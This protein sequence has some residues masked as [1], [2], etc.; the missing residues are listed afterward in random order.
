VSVYIVGADGSDLVKIGRASSPRKRLRDMQ[1]GSPLRLKLLGIA[2]APEWADVQLE[3][4]LHAY[5]ATRRRHGEW[6]D[7]NYGGLGSTANVGIGVSR[8]TQRL[9]IPTGGLHGHPCDRLRL[10]L[11]C[12]CAR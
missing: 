8:V 9:A 6:F 7:L 11:H 3:G 12:G 1:T 10:G 4:A 2:S 5:F